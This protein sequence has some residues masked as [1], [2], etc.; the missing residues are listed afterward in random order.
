MKTNLHHWCRVKIQSMEDFCPSSQF[1]PPQTIEN[2]KP[3]A[4]TESSS[5]SSTAASIV[6]PDRRYSA[7]RD[8]KTAQR[9]CRPPKSETNTRSGWCI[10]GC[11]KTRI[12]QSLCWEW[13]SVWNWARR[14]HKGIALVV[15]GS[16]DF[17][18]PLAA[19]PSATWGIRNVAQLAS[20]IWAPALPTHPAQKPRAGH[21]EN[22]KSFYT[23]SVLLP[24][25]FKKQAKSNKETLWC[26]NRKLA[27]GEERVLHQNLSAAFSNPI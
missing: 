12:P 24:R 10:S 8:I 4:D 15:G 17:S 22:G 1:C 27:L 14:K 25:E 21:A 19:W 9:H 11:K 26:F 13:P 16:L 6:C 23:T 20:S 7:A 2:Q 18:C 5:W 3:R